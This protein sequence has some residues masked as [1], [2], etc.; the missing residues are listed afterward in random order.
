[1]TMVFS[2]RAVLIGSGLALG[3]CVAPPRFG[4]SAGLPGP[5]GW[6]YAMLYGPLNDNGV[7]IS[8][9]DLSTINPDLLRRKCRSTAPIAPVRSWS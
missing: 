8:A 4:P 6:D 5:M 9:L 3:G 1:M 7:E 2:R